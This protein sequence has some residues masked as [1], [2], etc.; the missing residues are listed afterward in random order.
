MNKFTFLSNILFKPWAISEQ[1]ALQSGHYI[2][3]LI[4]PKLE[5]FPGQEP[6][7]SKPSAAT[8]IE[9]SIK[10]P[11]GY[12]N[13]PV[14]SVAIIP[15]LGPMMKNDQFCG[16]AGMSTIGRRIQ[17]AD[18][19]PHI[20]S[21]VLKFDTPGGSVDGVKSLGEII[22]ATNKPIIAFIDGSCFS[23]GMWLASCADKI[24]A[25]TDI[26]EI[27]SIG[28][29]TSFV[30]MQPI[31][32]KAGVKFHEIYS[33]FSEDKNKLFREILAGDYKNYRKLKLDPLAVEFRRTIKENRPNATDEIMTG[34]TYFAKEVIGTLVDEIASFEQTIIMASEM[35]STT[36]N[37]TLIINSNIQTMKLVQIGTVLAVDEF[38]TQDGGIFLTEEQAVQLDDKLGNM[39]AQLEL[40]NKERDE[41]AG[42]L[43][44]RMNAQEDLQLEVQRLSETIETLGQQPAAPAAVIVTDSNNISANTENTVFDPNADFVTNLQNI[45]KEYF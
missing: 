5:V 18:N 32:E 28:V 22:K 26:D 36:T 10:W 34:K 7:L 19:H 41:L 43:A 12:D 21:I 44:E 9:D 33:E 40:A 16:P 8:Y 13:A 3:S 23:A 35:G 1:F 42:K 38:E 45:G 39:S 25:S 17:E 6:E 30:D 2:A 37:R 4:D 27:G 20:S 14:G 29:M 11:D 15:I 24:V 31:W